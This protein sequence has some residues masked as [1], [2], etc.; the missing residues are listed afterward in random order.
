[1]MTLKELKKL[2]DGALWDCSTNGAKY[3]AGSVD[4]IARVEEVVA[5]MR[6]ASERAEFP[7]ERPHPR[8]LDAWADLLEGKE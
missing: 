7:D 3:I 8:L 6:E 4:L 1:M 2:F 5:E